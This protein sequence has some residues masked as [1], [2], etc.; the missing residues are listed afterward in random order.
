M[1]FLDLLIIMY[2]NNIMKVQETRRHTCRPCWGARGAKP[3]DLFP[4]AIRLSP[5]WEALRAFLQPAVR[6]M[7]G[8]TGSTYPPPGGKTW[9]AGMAAALG[10]GRGRALIGLGFFALFVGCGMPMQANR[11]W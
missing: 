5:A 6:A 7:V 10:I 4:F 2:I 9:H 1:I 3:L 11:P 8:L